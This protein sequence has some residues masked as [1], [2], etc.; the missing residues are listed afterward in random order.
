MRLGALV[1]QAEAKL[2]GFNSRVLRAE[3]LTQRHL[4]A[5]EW[6]PLGVPESGSC[7]MLVISDEKHEGCERVAS[8]VARTGL[9]AM[10]ASTAWAA[11]AA[12]GSGHWGHALTLF[13]RLTLSRDATNE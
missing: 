5:T 7:N 2:D 3:V 12:A 10:L 13:Y 6:R 9:A 4:Y 1:G 8:R 11:I